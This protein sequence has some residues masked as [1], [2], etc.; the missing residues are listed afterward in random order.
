MATSTFSV[1]MESDVK[2]ELDKVCSQ[3]GLNISVAINMFARAVVRERKIPF[4]LSLAPSSSAGF[5]AFNALRGEARTN[6]LRSMSL[7]AINAEIS[8]ARSRK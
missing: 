3:L 7:K 8:K 2:N 6:G 5:E 1:R 4:D